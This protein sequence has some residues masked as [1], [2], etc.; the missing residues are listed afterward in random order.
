[1]KFLNLIKNYIDKLNEIIGQGVSWLTSVLVLV[2]CYDVFN[3]Y[4]MDK[5]YVQVQVQELQWHIF[6]ILF[7]LGA[8]Y[9]LKYDRHVRVDIVYARLSA[10]K[11][12]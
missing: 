12:A 11:K 7:L 6:G 2:V 9:S 8:A 10:S 3:R 5:S 4:V 1:M